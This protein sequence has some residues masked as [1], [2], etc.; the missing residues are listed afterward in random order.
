MLKFPVFGSWLFCG[1]GGQILMRAGSILPGMVGKCPSFSNSS[2][3][4]CQ[5]LRNSSCIEL[6]P[7][8][9]IVH[10]WITCFN[11]HKAFT[12]VPHLFRSGHSTRKRDKML[13]RTCQPCLLILLCQI[14]SQRDMYL[15][16]EEWIVSVTR[17]RTQWRDRIFLFDI[18]GIYI[19]LYNFSRSNWPTREIH[20]EY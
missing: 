9:R 4:L 8:S 2:C 19:G 16:I 6:N 13:T 15:R 10:T 20:Y 3:L 12:C 5:L 7:I 14:I 18:V 17:A 1:G 11:L